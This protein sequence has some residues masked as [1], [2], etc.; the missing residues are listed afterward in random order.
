MASWLWR[1]RCELLK[2]FPV[3]TVSRL[4]VLKH[5]LFVALFGSD[6]RGGK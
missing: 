2:H 6:Q 3:T 4:A 5:R 1:L